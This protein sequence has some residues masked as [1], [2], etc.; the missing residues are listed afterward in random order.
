[1]SVDRKSARRLVCPSTHRHDW[2]VVKNCHILC[3]CVTRQSVSLSF[4][5]STGTRVNSSANAGIQ[6]DAIS[7]SR[8]YK[9]VSSIFYL[10]FLLLSRTFKYNASY[11]DRQVVLYYDTVEPKKNLWLQKILL[12]NI[13]IPSGM[14][15]FIKPLYFACQW[16]IFSYSHLLFFFI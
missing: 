9:P 8:V 2:C 11:V 16:A 4:W 14:F 1:M 13:F 6:I 10:S 7:F 3:I 15:F 5:F 12:F